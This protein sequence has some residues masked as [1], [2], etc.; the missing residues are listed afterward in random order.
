MSYDIGVGDFSP[1]DYCQG[2][3]LAAAL[4]LQSFFKSITPG[5]SHSTH[6]PFICRTYVV[7][8]STLRYILPGSSTLAE[9]GCIKPPDLHTELAVPEKS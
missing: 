6:P 5:H 4:R 3:A 8:L 7:A 1:F 9:L 2:M